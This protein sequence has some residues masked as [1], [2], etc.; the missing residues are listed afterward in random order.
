M[1]S[2]A[3]TSLAG[4]EEL[5]PLSAPGTPPN[6][7]RLPDVPAGPGLEIKDVCGE[8]LPTCY[9]DPL[10]RAVFVLRPYATGEGNQSEPAGRGLLYRPGYGT[11]I[12][13]KHGTDNHAVTEGGQT[14]PYQRRICIL[15]RA[16]H[17]F[18]PGSKDQGPAQHP[19]A[20]PFTQRPGTIKDEATLAAIRSLT[21]PVSTIT[22]RA[23]PSAARAT[24]TSASISPLPATAAQMASCV[25]RLPG[26]SVACILS[27]TR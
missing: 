8:N 10:P 26:E 9:P 22:I 15:H 2:R 11:G 6:A 21:F 14:F 27:R 7:H 16:R 18:A 20:H 24:P 5:R 13:R 17:E 25:N 23:P 3:C 4:P 12:V 1:G 19:S